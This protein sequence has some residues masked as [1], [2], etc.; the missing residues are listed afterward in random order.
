MEGQRYGTQIARMTRMDTDTID[1]VF[2]FDQKEENKINNELGLTQNELTL[3]E[4]VPVRFSSVLFSDSFLNQGF[5]A[6]FAVK[7]IMHRKGR[8]ERKVFGSYLNNY[9]LNYNQKSQIRAYPRNPR[10][11]CSLRF[12]EYEL[13][14]QQIQLIHR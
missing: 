3:P 2:V 12:D 6:D 11:P 7:I 8:K 14:N 9:V 10:H 13:F 1:P 4:F 5:I